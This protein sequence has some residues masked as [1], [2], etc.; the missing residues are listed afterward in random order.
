MKSIFNLLLAIITIS[1]TLSQP[2][3]NAISVTPQSAPLNHRSTSV[4]KGCYRPNALVSSQL[5][6]LTATRA[7]GIPVTADYAG[8]YFAILQGRQLLSCPPAIFLNSNVSDIQALHLSKREV[9][10]QSEGTSDDPCIVTLNLRGFLDH[11]LDAMDAAGLVVPDY[12]AGWFSAVQD[13]NYGWE[14]GLPEPKH[15]AD[16]T[17]PTS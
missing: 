17:S 16:V 2:H 14:C 12:L 9:T 7:R 3:H 10:P 11:H 8:Y 15:N 5:A 4:P 6:E 1:P 13:L